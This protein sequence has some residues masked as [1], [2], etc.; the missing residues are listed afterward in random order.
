MRII[1]SLII[2]SAFIASSSLAMAE[3]VSAEPAKT[4]TSATPATPD[5]SAGAAKLATQEKVAAPAVSG[6]EQPLCVQK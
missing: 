3:A 2:A 5:S 4:E 6:L 1:I